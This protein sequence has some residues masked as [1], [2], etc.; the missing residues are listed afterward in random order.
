L[1]TE[2]LRAALAFAAL[3]GWGAASASS[4]AD[5]AGFDPWGYAGSDRC[6][7][8]H[9]EKYDG[10]RQTF[11]AT[12]VKDA[13]KNPEAVLGDFSVPG[14][15]FTLDD[16]EYT[17]GGHW[18]QRYMKKIGDDYYVLPK[19]WSVSSQTWRPYNVWAWRKMPYGK[20]CKGCH[21]T[22]Y[23]P[24]GN[25]P[26]SEHRI[27]CEACHGPGWNHAS[28]EGTK[29]IVNPRK[30]PPD[31]ANMICAACHVRGKDRSGEYH[32][33]VGY[34]PGEDLGAYYVPEKKAPEESNTQSI[35]RLWGEWEEK[36]ASNAGRQCDVCGINGASPD[37]KKSAGAMDFC[38]SCHDFADDK[39]AQ[40]T[41]HPAT[42]E[43]ACSDCH[44]Q[45]QKDIMNPQ[46]FD[47]H[48]P[49]YF[50]LH[51]ENCYDRRFENACVA[52]HGSKGT[53]WARGIVERWLR[54]V[55]LD[56]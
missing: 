10:W 35:A 18:D 42:V 31:R 28:T 9:R 24:T 25:V 13:K 20:Y 50:L 5:S 19:L 48:T 39:Y 38:K 47:V 4:G 26:V 22:N 56:H 2:A 41:H 27:G 14:L 33:P 55:E 36:R 29:P 1:R 53:E 6:G 15:G 30:I 44:L 11:H 49:E 16:V 37:K 34:L 23:D 21:V 7:E 40:H 17:I 51:V 12:V 43:I 52:C 3:L 54:P 8:C 46:T 45:R 32:F